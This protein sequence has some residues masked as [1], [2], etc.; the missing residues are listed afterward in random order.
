MK[1]L[2][3]AEAAGMVWSRISMRPPGVPEDQGF[4]RMKLFADEPET[5]ASA[6]SPP[7][8]RGH[9][10]RKY[11]ATFFGIVC[12]ALLV[13]EAPEFWLSYREQ[14]VL[15]A[16]IQQREFPICGGEDQSIRERSRR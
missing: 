15:L 4:D 6:A 3:S 16:R 5:G 13:G 10:F 1:F 12:L 14:T 2:P 8:L 9:L 11:A 7:L